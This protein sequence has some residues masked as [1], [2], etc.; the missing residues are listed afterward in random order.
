MMIDRP[1]T[2]LA[3]LPTLAVCA[4][5]WEG[6]I[7]VFALPPFVL[8]PLSA[9]ERTSVSAAE[10]SETAVNQESEIDVGGVVSASRWAS[11]C[12]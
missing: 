11:C 2:V 3:T 4:F 8:P 1:K 7:R 12:S 9:A 6:A 10:Y 5:A